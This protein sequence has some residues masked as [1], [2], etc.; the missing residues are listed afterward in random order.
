MQLRQGPCPGQSGHG[1]SGFSGGGASCYKC[2]PG[3]GGSNGSDGGNSTKYLGGKGSGID[4]DLLSMK[5]FILT[6]GAGRQASSS[7]NQICFC[8]VYLFVKFVKFDC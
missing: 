8:V 1:G 5:N 7:H 2:D 3:T 4:L 6:P